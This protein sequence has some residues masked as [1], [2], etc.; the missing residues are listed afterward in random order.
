MLH[1]IPE[2]RP[3]ANQILRHPWLWQPPP[4]IN[5]RDDLMQHHNHQPQQIKDAVNATFR[6]FQTNSPQAS[7][8]GPVVMSE[9]A[10]RRAKDK[11]RIN[12]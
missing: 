8:L 1:I 6:V 5:R 7:N 4:D 3:K 2:K 12:S 11:T 10:R 9:L